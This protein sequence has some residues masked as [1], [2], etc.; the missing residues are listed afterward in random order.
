MGKLPHMKRQN[1]LLK[2]QNWHLNFKVSVLLSK[3]LR[4]KITNLFYCC[5]VPMPDQIK[6]RAVLG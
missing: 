2:Q 5:V 3:V 1:K 4:T 6:T